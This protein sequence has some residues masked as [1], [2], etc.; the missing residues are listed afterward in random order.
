PKG[1]SEADA[2]AILQAAVGVLESTHDFRAE[3]LDLALRGFVER[4]GRS[5]GEVFGILRV[6]VTGQKVSPP[7][8]ETMEIVGREVVLLRLRAAADQ[9]ASAT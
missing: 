5:A 8:F 4:L 6:A 9:L 3:S 2:A 1:M 7:L